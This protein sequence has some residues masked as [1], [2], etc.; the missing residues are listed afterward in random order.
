MKSRSLAIVAVLC[1]C[2][3]VA[4]CSKGPKK[5]ADLPKLNPTTIV[6][7][8][9]NGTPCPGAQVSLRLA[10][11]TGGRTWNLAGVTD[12]S[13]KLVLKTDGNWD[14]A[15]AGTYEVMVTKEEAEIE[16]GTEPG[17]SDTVKSITRR[18][19]SKYSNPKT[20]GLTA[21]VED[22]KSNTIELKCGEEI[23][24]AVKVM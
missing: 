12:A 6:L 18:V 15:P 10:Q 4:G 8:Y 7:T 20:S 21:V 5:P 24:E 14:G 11:S 22:G 19:D 9:D 17:A 2:A 3:V 13:G 16:K 1:L 23:S